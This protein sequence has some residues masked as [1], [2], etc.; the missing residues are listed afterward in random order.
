MIITLP[1][2]ETHLAYDELHESLKGLSA[3]DVESNKD[4]YRKYLV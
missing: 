3:F 2:S 4:I 1:F